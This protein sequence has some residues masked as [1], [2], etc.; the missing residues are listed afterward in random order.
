MKRTIHGAAMA[1]GCVL[2]V[3]GAA[4]G[5]EAMYTAAATMPSPGAVLMR[6]QFHWFRYDDN[7]ADGS[8]R[9]DRYEFLSTAYIG[10][11]RDF[12]VNIDVPIEMKRSSF[13]PP[14]R[15]E[16][17]TTVPEVDFTFK[18]RFLRQD[19]G[20]IDTLRAA[21]LFG[22]NVN[23]ED[24]AEVNPHLG[25]VITKVIGRHG[26]NAEVHYTLNT[27]GDR[28]DNFGGEGPDDALA[29]NLAY[30]WRF[31]PDAYTSTSTGAWYVT[32]ELNHM[33]ETNG[34]S[35]LRFSPGVM[36]EG[37]TFGFEIMG[38]LPVYQDLDE[39][40]DLEFGIGVGIRVL[41]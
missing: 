24:D 17:D 18:W 33:Y 2:L 30:L 38:Q 16:D 36:F 23:I 10:L 3:A 13:P 15:D 39:R 31:Y 12:A 27:G 35:E 25:A 41:F 29:T 37:R 21:L 32:F 40:P 5:Q 8:D 4:R 9:T 28:R 6:E 26:F 34:D 19:P 1:A 11:F 20:E 22:A 7:P 14:T